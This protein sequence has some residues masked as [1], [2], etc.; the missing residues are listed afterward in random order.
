MARGLN[1]G[2]SSITH[3]LV[4]GNVAA[5]QSAV[6]VA[7][8]GSRARWLCEV[9]V[10]GMLISPLYWAIN[11]GKLAIAEFILAD[12]L[13]IRGDMT[14]YYYGRQE[15]FDYHPDLV[16]QLT[17]KAPGLI[18]TLLDGCLWHSK[19]RSD[20]RHVKVNYYVADLY[21][22]PER[23]PDVWTS[24]LAVF[25]QESGSETFTHPAVRKVL[26]L[27]WNAFGLRLFVLSELGAATVLVL[28]VLTHTQL[29]AGEIGDMGCSPMD[30]TL[31]IMNA[32]SAFMLLTYQLCVITMQLVRRKTIPV[33]FKGMQLTVPRYLSHFWTWV[34]LFAGVLVVVLFFVDGCG[35]VGHHTATHRRAG[36]LISTRIVPTEIAMQ[37]FAALLLW[38]QITQATIVSTRMAAFTYIIGIMVDDLVNT[39]VM[40]AILLL[41][42]A[43]ALSIVHDAPF[44][45]FQDSV[46]ILTEEIL[47]LAA[48]DILEDV[49]WLT[50]LLVVV[51]IIAVVVGFLNILV[52]QLTITYK[53][54]NKHKEG[55]ALK[56]RASV[57]LDIEDLLPV[58]WRT[59]IFRS[60]GFDEPLAFGKDDVGPPG[61]IQVLEP[62]GCDRYEPDRIMRFTGASSQNDPWAVI[63][64]DDSGSDRGA[65]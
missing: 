50:M 36:Q 49:S 24:P 65:D 21:G 19:D 12:L 64:E 2:G 38:V 5:F 32:V 35:P 3:G 43:S 25:V 14:G 62:E 11:D 26:E 44:A 18:D 61:G 9:N 57:C 42:F 23:K 40:I 28:F 59:K 39:F 56:H 52:A 13:T 20:S 53:G 47:G 16:Q 7:P 37:A 48:G 55:F 51:F 54:L 58:R 22:D 15:L 63:D 46:L 6:A 34:R 31:S 60:F 8:R 45:T 10:N 29:V 4:S 1:L 41:A 30:T 33:G 27:K 17:S